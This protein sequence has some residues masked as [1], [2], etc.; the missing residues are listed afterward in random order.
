MWASSSQNPGYRARDECCDDPDPCVE[1]APPDET[2]HDHHAQ[3]DEH[4]DDLMGELAAGSEP[5]C[6]PEHAHPSWWMLRERNDGGADA[7][8]VSEPVGDPQR[9]E[10]VR[11]AVTAHEPPTLGEQVREANTGS[12]DDSGGEQADEASFDRRSC[13]RFHRGDRIGAY[14]ISPWCRRRAG[15]VD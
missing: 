15:D 14:G 4:G 8:R 2:R 9:D 6:D 11:E 7:E 13:R 5:R 12:D 1:V 3:P 10:V